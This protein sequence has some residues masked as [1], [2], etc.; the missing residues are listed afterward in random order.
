MLRDAV[1]KDT[2]GIYD[3]LIK[4][5]PDIPDME[6]EMPKKMEHIK[7]TIAEWKVIVEDGKIIAAI[8]IGK[9]KMHIGKSVIIKGDVGE[10]SVLPEYQGKGT[11]TRLM[12]ETIAWMKACGQYDLAR[13]GGYCRFYSRFGFSR[14]FRRHMAISVGKT[15]RA[16]NSQIYEGKFEIDPEHLSA[17][18]NFDPAIHLD[19]LKKL[20]EKYQHIYNGINYLEDEREFKESPLFFVYED[21]GQV[22]GFIQVTEYTSEIRDMDAQLSIGMFEYDRE[23][24]WA[25]DSLFKHLYNYALEKGYDK[26]TARP[27]FEP[28]FIYDMCQTGIHFYLVEYYG[29]SAGNMFQILNMQTLFKNLTDEFEYRLSRSAASQWEGIIELSTDKECIQLIVENNKIKVI[30]GQKPDILIHLKEFHLLNLILGL[31]SF[32]EAES[33]VGKTLIPG[34]TEYALIKDLFPG[35]VVCSGMWG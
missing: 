2:D 8:H 3:V 35:S 13:L 6:I 17:I 31:M 34:N 7:K 18:K 19:S 25:M 21:E 11:G 32:T 16:G 22:A 28:G 15:S 5:F 10:V 4:A 1:Q 33:A 20:I 9:H 29:G 24:P 26:I 23:K 27:H 12:D 14:F 30:S